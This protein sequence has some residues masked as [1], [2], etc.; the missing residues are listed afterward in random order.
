MSPGEKQM[1]WSEKLYAAIEPADPYLD[2]GVLIVSGHY[3]LGAMA[4][5]AVAWKA[6]A[7]GAAAYA[8][9]VMRIAPQPV[10]VLGAASSLR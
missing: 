7:I 3:L 9:T 10:A 4:F 2:D 1:G 8:P 5:G 6:I